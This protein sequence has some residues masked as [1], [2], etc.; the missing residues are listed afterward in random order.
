[1][2]AAA[3]PLARDYDLDPL[4]ERIGEAR[5]VLLGEASHGTSDYYTW[6]HRISER[7]I[8]EKG[9]NFI[10]VEGDWP[11]C[12]AVDRYI[13]GL[14]DASSPAAV[15]EAFG[16]WPTWM[17]ANEEVAALVRSLKAI[18]DARSPDRRARFY[19]LDAYSLWDSLHAVVGYAEREAPQALEAVRSA[20][21]CFEPFDDVEEYA[22]AV[23]WGLDGCEDQVAAMLAELRT[24]RAGGDAAFDAEQNALVA[25]NAEKYYRTMMRGG[26]AGWNVRDRHMAETLDRLLDRHGPAAKAIV[27]EHNTHVGDARATDMA[28][29]GMVNVGQLAREHYARGE[30]V[31]FGFGSHRGTVIAGDAWDAPMRRMP[32]PEA[33][34]GSSEALMHRAFAGEDQLL[35]FGDR[36]ADRR[37]GGV[38]ATVRSAS[39]TTPTTKPETTSRPTSPT[40]TTPSCSSTKPGPCD[41]CGPGHAA[42]PPV[43]TS[44]PKPFRAGFDS[45]PRFG[46]RRLARRNSRRATVPA[47]PGLP[48]GRRLGAAARD[49]RRHQ[50]QQAEA[51]PVLSRRVVDALGGRPAVAD[52]P[53]RDQQLK[54]VRPPGLADERRQ[55][56]RREQAG[57]DEIMQPQ[58]R[59]VV[60]VSKHERADGEPRR[61]HHF[62]GARPHRGNSEVDDP[63]AGGRQRSRLTWRR[64][65]LRRLH[66][67]SS[68]ERPRR[69]A[70]TC[71]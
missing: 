38:A 58:G 17:W 59:L 34:P 46:S 5:C 22:H 9:F 10:A 62:D 43:A 33:R 14:E 53:D 6:R 12:S 23:S 11:D 64:P 55:G 7:L 13:R 45:R 44:R 3:R 24:R 67:R 27:W 37:S 19:G 30:V 69:P 68:W 60:R 15:L 66:T 8:R 51:H 36:E 26:G 1:M 57:R 29:A 25:A 20:Y 18:N 35:I 52:Q 41:L 21:R 31:L 54:K 71:G 39:S 70:R 65:S 49:D 42:A 40:G 47:V 4:L 2:R 56:Q 61:K 50:Q 48:A 32:V 16:R 63:D 28:G